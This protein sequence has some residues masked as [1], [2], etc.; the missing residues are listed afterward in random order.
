MIYIRTCNMYAKRTYFLN[1]Q[2]LI[3]P[4]ATL[5]R[6]SINWAGE[7]QWRNKKNINTQKTGKNL[8]SVFPLCSFNR[9]IVIRSHSDTNGSFHS[10]T[11]FNK[12]TSSSRWVIL[13]VFSSSCIDIA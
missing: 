2:Q 8:V 13:C 7:N 5:A 11:S 4:I 10:F 12:P 9:C 3:L 6:A 1:N